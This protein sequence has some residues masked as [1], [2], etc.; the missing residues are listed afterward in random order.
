MRRFASDAASQGRY[1]TEFEL[2]KTLSHENFKYSLEQNLNELGI[3][4]HS[5]RGA[6][7]LKEAQ[8]FW[9][10]HFFTDE[11]VLW[12]RPYAGAA[13]CVHWFL[14]QG[15]RIVYLSGRDVPNMSRGTLTAL[16]RDGFPHKGNAISL[17]LKPDFH[18][19][20]LL[21]KKQAMETI[22]S[23]GGV[24]A[25]FDN[26]PANV[27]MFLEEFPEA[28]HI[29]YK[30]AHARHIDLAGPRFLGVKT[31]SELGF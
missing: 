6:A 22:R 12:D 1:H 23:E 16:E 9:F 19:D 13:A 24:V 5:E 18:M 10:T 3:S 8:D 25:T 31:W 30:S 29:H 4:R 20:D 15:V 27:K 21:F 17:V 14:N 28:W 7:F 11:G 26:E 2:L